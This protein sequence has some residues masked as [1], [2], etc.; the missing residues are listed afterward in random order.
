MW[1]I[2]SRCIATVAVVDD[3]AGSR[4]SLGWLLS[5]AGLEIHELTGP[6]S[7][8]DEESAALP[9]AAH[10]V[11]CDHNLSA[12]ANYATFA[13]AE[14]VASATKHGFPA[15]LCTRYAATD[16]LIIRPLLP[17][18]P[19]LL[20]P[21]ELREPE[22]LHDAFVDCVA[23]L[24]GDV[25]P[26]RKPWRTQ[27]VVEQVDDTDRTF[28]VSLPAWDI[29]QVVRLRLDDVPADLRRAIKIGFR[30]YAM[31]NIGADRTDRLFVKE[32]IR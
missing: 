27:L 5:D 13:G 19:V 21:N 3:D 1:Q 11:I 32:W 9:G 22:E 10:A 29:D 6:L 2:R 31:A 7:T 30:S 17:Y 24:A 15:I 14:L 16:I 12:R 18:I 23:E 20:P 8:V 28:C 25:P 4:E 26:E